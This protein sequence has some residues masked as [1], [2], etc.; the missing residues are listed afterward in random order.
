MD[1][2]FRASLEKLGAD[3][4]NT[5]HRFME[6]EALYLKFLKKFQDDQSFSNIQKYLEEQN[7]EEVFKSAHTL[8]GVAANLGLDPVARYASDLTEMLRGK[9]SLAEA[10]AESLNTAKTELEKAYHAFVGIL[11]EHL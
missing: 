10:D 3:V 8:K 7:A 2:A 11:T 9:T 6:N 4:D 1:A 5:L